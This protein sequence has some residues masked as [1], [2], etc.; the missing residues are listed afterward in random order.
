MLMSLFCNCYL[1][2]R[3]WIFEGNVTISWQAFSKINR[4]EKHLIGIEFWLLSGDRY[5]TLEAMFK[6]Q[7]D[8]SEQHQFKI[9]FIV[10]VL[11]SFL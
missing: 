6:L 4:E 1:S 11:L 7:R 5:F 10:L 2:L 8:L 3:N 9:T